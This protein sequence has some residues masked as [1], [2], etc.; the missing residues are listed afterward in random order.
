SQRGTARKVHHRARELWRGSATRLVHPRGGDDRVAAPR[1]NVTDGRVEL[2]DE[3]GP[4][5]RD[6]Q[7]RDRDQRRRESSP[8]VAPAVPFAGP[9]LRYRGH[10]LIVFGFVTI[11]SGR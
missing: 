4:G 5:A 8:E 2:A 9:P 7:D 3:V 11:R 6:G 10:G 1:P